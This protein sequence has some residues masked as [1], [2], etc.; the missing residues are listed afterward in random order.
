MIRSYRFLPAAL[1]FSLLLLHPPH[2]AAQDLRVTVTVEGKKGKNA[3]GIIKEI[4]KGVCDS[5][6]DYL[7]ANLPDIKIPETCNTDAEGACLL[8]RAEAIFVSEPPALNLFLELRNLNN[9]SIIKQKSH[10]IPTAKGMKNYKDLLYFETTAA[11]KDLVPEG[12]KPH[13]VKEAVLKGKGETPQ[14]QPE[15]KEKEEIEET[16]EEVEGKAVEEKG[17]K[18]PAEK[19]KETPPTKETGEIKPPLRTGL[20]LAVSAKDAKVTLDEKIVGTSPLG[21]IPNI[22]VGKHRINVEKSGYK[23]YSESLTV[24]AKDGTYRHDIILESKRATKKSSI[25]KKWWF[26]TALAVIVGG[27]AAGA[28]AAVLIQ[29][30]ETNAVPFPGY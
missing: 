19:L 24:P 3:K 29:K 26:W 21:I 12:W 10:T 17:E 1:F 6:I 2:A 22:P 15:T 27:G 11:M 13:I 5:I 16:S 7:T 9:D 25:A 4:K 30:D 8:V 18:T 14:V 23:K 28:A 20:L